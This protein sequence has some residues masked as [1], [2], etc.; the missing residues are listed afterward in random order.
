[1]VSD[2]V[3]NCNLTV[4]FSEIDR[5][6]ELYF[7]GQLSAGIRILVGVVGFFWSLLE[8]V[9]NPLKVPSNKSLFSMAKVA[10]MQNW[11]PTSR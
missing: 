4:F 1:M 6:V 9:W 11:L 8:C 10:Q 2:I 7:F 3:I 5:I